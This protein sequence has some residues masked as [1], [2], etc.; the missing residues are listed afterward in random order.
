MKILFDHQIFAWQKY[1]GVSKYFCELICRLPKEAWDISLILSNNHYI[2]EFDFYK[3]SKHF[4]YNFPFR[5][6]ERIMLELN[7]P[8][9]V[10]KILQGNFDIFH[11]THFGSYSFPFLKNKRMVTTFHDTNFSTYNINYKQEKMQ[12]KALDRADR[13]IAISNN[14]KNDIISTFNYADVNN[15]E[16]IHHGVSKPIPDIILG[17]RL[18]KDDYIL[19]VGR[20]EEYK[21]F[22]RIVE[23]FSL[24]V[25]NKNYKNLKLVCTADKFSNDEISLFKSKNISS[26]LLHMPCNELQMGNLYKNALLFVFPSIYEGFG[27]PILEAMSYECPTVVANASCFP[28]ISGD[29][30][31]FFN[32]YE[33][34]D[35]YDKIL[36][37][38]DDSTIRDALINRGKDLCSKMTWEHCVDKHWRLYNSLV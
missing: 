32:P 23:A 25:Q 7:K 18:I 16:V 22:K 29:A 13:V 38:I 28:E 10:L 21:N 19:Y 20:R 24:V 17:E 6:L 5:G 4:F 33:V 30:S 2:D 35:M 9:S 37:C 36:F 31:L 34:E 12:K 26:N 1:G 15:I 11:Q 14:T 27:M 3:S 8:Y